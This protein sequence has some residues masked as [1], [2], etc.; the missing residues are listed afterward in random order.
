MKTGRHIAIVGEDWSHIL[1]QEKSEYM[2]RKVGI[3]LYGY[4][5]ISETLRTM[6]CMS[7]NVEMAMS[8]LVEIM[9]CLIERQ[10]EFAN[11]NK[12]YGPALGSLQ[13][14]RLLILQADQQMTEARK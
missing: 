8:P 7:A 13:A 6:Q 12:K 4:G 5:D 11:L 3:I 9:N 14:A 2:V 1:G 10:E